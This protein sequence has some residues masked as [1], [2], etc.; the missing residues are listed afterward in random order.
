VTG[1]WLTP[2]Y[3]SPQADAGYDVTDYR[4]VARSSAIRGWP[5]GQPPGQGCP[6]AHVRPARGAHVYQG[7]ELGLPEVTDLPAAA[8]KD[9]T[10]LRTGGA[11]LGRDGCRVPMPWSGSEPPFGFG[12]SAAA[13][14]PQPEAWAELTVERQASA[15]VWFARGDDSPGMVT[16]S[17]W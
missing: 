14:L 2:F 11:E 8:R 12:P 1:A 7:E 13:W 5:A 16:S 3:P 10:F 4:D 6:A 15:P 9:P 17:D